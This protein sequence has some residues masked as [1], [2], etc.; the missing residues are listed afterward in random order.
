M[1]RDPKME[2]A[3]A[4]SASVIKVSS[5]PVSQ[6]SQHLKSSETLRYW[7]AS[8]GFHMSILFCGEMSSLSYSRRAFY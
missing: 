8:C 2:P 5:E 7:S 4:T 3:A 1:E 6:W